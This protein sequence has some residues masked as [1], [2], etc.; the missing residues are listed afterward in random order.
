M[1]KCQVTVMPENRTVSVQKGTSLL[2]AAKKAGIDIV[3]PCGRQGT[4]GKC[5]VKVISGACKIGEDTHFP[6]DIKNAGFIPACQAEVESDLVIEVPPASRLTKHK[7]VLSS[8]KTRF[9]REHDYFADK[10]MDPFSRKYFIKLEKPTLSDSM[11]DL[12]RLKTALG[13]AYGLENLQ[14]NLECLKN[15]P[16]ALRAGDWQITATVADMNGVD[17]IV[18]LEPGKSEKPAMGLAVDLGTTTVVVSILEL[19]NGKVIDKAGSYN[20]QAA[21]GSD[22]ISRIV[23]ADETANGLDIMQ[24]AV[25]NTVNEL[26]EELIVKNG[27]ERKELSSMVVGGNTVMTH[28]FFGVTATYLRLDPYVPG[29]IQ[30]PAVKARQL[31]VAINPEAP[32]IS[33]PSVASYVGGDITA[34]VLATMLT[35]SKELT[36]FIDIGTNGELVLGNNEWMVTCSCSAGPAFEGSG[37]SCGMRAMDGAIDR[38]DI[39]GESFEVRCRTIGDCKPLG[40]CGSGLIYSLSEMME[41]GIIDRAGQINENINSPRIR[42][43]SEELEYV[44]VFARDSGSGKDITVT[45]SDIKNLL[46]AK[47]AIFAGIRTMLQEV[48]LNVADIDR[49]Y[50]A[51]GFGNY[52]NITDAVNIGLLPDLPAEKYE[53]VGNSCLQGAM[54]VLLSREAYREAIEISGR[55]TYLELSAGNR[56]MEEFVSAVFIPHTD[57]SLFPTQGKGTHHSRG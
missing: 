45:G 2:A 10:K 56:F 17:E 37:I 34:G 32:V 39:D 21:Y 28:L 42:R 46:R 41:A 55:M 20:K 7:V 50:I 48:Q 24:R 22:V 15:L 27:L 30:F 8:Q 18:G 26:I 16:E 35:Y 52:I 53:Y 6:P 25:I 44:L 12:D 23:Y 31:G 40:I 38:I 14:I 5:A 1:E 29:A 51:G 11:N 4:C 33:I 13:K 57:L 36:L 43:S 49:V 9:S 19:E 47:G 3:S 54:L